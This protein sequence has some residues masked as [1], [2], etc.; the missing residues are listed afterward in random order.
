[1]NQENVKRQLDQ[2]TD[3]DR[4]ATQQATRHYL[5]QFVSVDGLRLHFVSKG[6]G[7]PVVFIHGNPGSHQDFSRTVLGDVSETYRAVAFDR[8]GHGYSERHNGATVTVEVQARLLRDAL[9]QL[10]IE[11]PIIVGHSWG[12]AVALAMALED[13]ENLA[14]LVLLAPAAYP[15]DT[16]QWWTTLPHLPFLGNLLLKTLTPLLGRTIVRDSLKDAYHPQPV[17]ADYVQAAEALWTRAE[18]IRA[19]AS[20]D[21]SLDGS[22]KVLSERY[23]EIRLPVV[24]VTG[25]SDLL[26]KPEEHACRLQR[27][28][29]GS[30]LMRLE[31][32]GHQIPQTRPESVIE[33]IEMVANRES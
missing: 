18:Q 8:P 24:I 11:R 25:D 5:G 29:S 16:T 12:G 14:G 31:G 7:R 20:D 26:V 32:V 28:V 1:M 9:E 27:S 6:A 15:G 10:S 21:R 13:Q 30:Q 19:C 33:A 17:Q 3:S 23:S 2:E 4:E 22:L